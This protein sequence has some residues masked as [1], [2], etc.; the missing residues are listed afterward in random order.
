LIETN[1]G[2]EKLKPGDLLFFGEKRENGTEKV[3]HVG[4]WMGN[5]QMIH[6]SGKVRISSF[7]PVSPLYDAYE[8][9]RFLRAKRIIQ[10]P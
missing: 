1:A 6:A 5:M 2:F 8:V 4:L 10:Q 7:D 9:G 3:V